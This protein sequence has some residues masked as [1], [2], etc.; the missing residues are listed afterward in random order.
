MADTDLP[1]SSVPAEAANATNTV[2]A[3]AGKIGVDYV[4]SEGNGTS[5]HFIAKN[6]NASS[7]IDILNY[8][9]W[10]AV[11][12]A[13]GLDEVPHLILTEYELT[14]G[15]WVSN[16]AKIIKA[17]VA[18]DTEMDPYENL[19]TGAETGFTYIFP[20]LVSQ[21]EHIQGKTSNTWDRKK[22]S[23]LGIALTKVIGSGTISGLV[24]RVAEG[25]ELVS[26]AF[27]PGFGAEEIVTYKGT[28]PRSIVVKFPLYNTVDVTGALQ[29]YEFVNLFKFQNLKTRT[30]YVTFIPPK[31]Y[32]IESSAYGGLYMPAAYVKE[33]DIKTIG[34]TRQMQMKD[35]SIIIPEAYRIEITFE[36]FI[37]ESSNIHLGSFSNKKVS[38]LRAGERVV[39]PKT[40]VNM[41]EEITSAFTEQQ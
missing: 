20:Y 41:V 18:G 38:I 35:K 6:I 14:Q 16:L 21:N 32:R 22:F 26:E 40:N 9:D 24:S 31:I 8:F 3:R 19:Y 5:A 12:T 28:N 1:T 11:P 17:I 30:S 7:T 4:Q 25:A 29:N 13:D 2:S 39:T 23:D 33:L 36:E 15:K 37:P 10:K 27:Y 34:T